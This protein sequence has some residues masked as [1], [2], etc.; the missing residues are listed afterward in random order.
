MDTLLLPLPSEQQ[1]R[2]PPLKSATNGAAL[3]LLNSNS[4]KERNSQLTKKFLCE[5][6]EKGI[7][8]TMSPHITLLLLAIILENFPS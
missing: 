5:G 4:E 1:S 2:L 7:L 6:S 3:L 8:L